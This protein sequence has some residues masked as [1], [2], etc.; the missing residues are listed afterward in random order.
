MSPRSGSTTVDA[1]IQVLTPY[2]GAHMA[3]AAVRSHAERM[4]LGARPPT[5]DEL[6]ELFEQLHR[7]LSVFVGKDKAEELMLAARTA[8]GDKGRGS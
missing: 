2:L 4:G 7:G 5:G 6:E 1:V 3:R 8:A